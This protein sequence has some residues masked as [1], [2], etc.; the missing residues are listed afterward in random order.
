M[1]AKHRWGRLASWNLGGQDV[2]KLDVAGRDLDIISVQEVSRG[3]EGWITENTELFHWV[4]HRAHDQWR[5][6]GVGFA[7]DKLDCI[8]GKVA[9]NRGVWILTRLKGIGRVVFGS[10]HCHTGA[11]NAVYQ[12][13][14]ARFAHECPRKW[15]QYSVWCGV[16]A[17]ELAQRVPWERFQ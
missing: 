17:N 11:T 2:H 7:N 10:L 3:E 16:D 8:I 1:C 15:R 14:V 13:A 12:A 6:T 9:T 5:A 4:L